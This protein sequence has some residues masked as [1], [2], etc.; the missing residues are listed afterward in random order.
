MKTKIKKACYRL[1]FQIFISV[2]V[3]V[4]TVFSFMSLFVTV[5]NSLKSN[6]EIIAN[7]FSLPKA[8]TIGGNV[9]YNFTKAWSG[10]KTSFLSSIVL[11]LI[12]AFVNCLLGS[13]LAYIFAYKDFYGKDFFF[14]VFMAVMLLPSIMGMPILVPFVMNTLHL[15][16]TYIGYLLPNFAGG[17]VGA[18]FLFRT[19]FGQQPRS[20]YESAQIEGAN[21]F[22]IYLHIAVP[23]SIAIILFH[24]V[25]VF[26]SYYN[27]Y[28]WPSLILD[29]KMTMMPK[30]LSLQGTFSSDD[31][32][33]AMY[34]M[35]VISCIPLVCTSAISMKYFKGGEFAAGMKL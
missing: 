3:I 2:F 30:M 11:A 8:K 7:V 5:I 19:F 32:K 17:Q 20:I 22:H 16:D 23:L 13:I 4:A 27:D 34:A 35:Y 10:V 12:G 6:S 33:G 29:T 14:M 9:L 21:D 18:L 26:G 31:A 15:G 28:L 25:G 24:F 1:D